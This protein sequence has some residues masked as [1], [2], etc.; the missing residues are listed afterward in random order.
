MDQTRMNAIVVDGGKG[1][2]EALKWTEMERPVPADG[3]LLIRVRAAGINRP[4]LL[5]R[6]GF[7]PPP[8]GAPDTLGLEVAGEAA[9]DAGRWRAGDR[10]TALLGG[11]G[12]AELAV[13]DARHVLPIPEG[14]DY[15][16]AA[17]LPET[18]SVTILRGSTWKPAASI[19]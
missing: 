11:G 5:Q 16:E 19:S 15:V 3:Q 6:C 18:V 1:P 17:V 4:D 8:P 12:Y 7:Y 14:L 9:N 2:P 13:V 10:V